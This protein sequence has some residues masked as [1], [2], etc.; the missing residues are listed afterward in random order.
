MDVGPGIGVPAELLRRR[1]D[2]RAAECDLVRAT[3]EGGVATAALYPRLTSPGS[4]GSEAGGI[5]AG[6]IVTA[7]IGSLTAVIDLPLFDAGARRAEVTAAEER[8]QQTLIAYRQTLL[9]ALEEV[10]AALIGHA[11]AGAR[12]TALREAVAANQLAADRKSTRLNSSH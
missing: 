6:D 1:P 12:E 5:G 3:A 9:R 4:L 2:L 11:G 7:V 10:E 8:A